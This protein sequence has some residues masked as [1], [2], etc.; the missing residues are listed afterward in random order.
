MGEVTS[1]LGEVANRG[2]LIIFWGVDPVTTHPRHFERYSLFPKGMF[3]PRGRADRTLVVV[4]IESHASADAADV[5]LQVKP[6][7]R[8]RGPLDAAGP[9]RRTA[10][11]TPNRCSPTPA[12]R[13]PPGRT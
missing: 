7:Q 4:D 2:D 6:G 9:G 3:V 12:C 8:L 1:S 5:F 10:S 13:W 11:R